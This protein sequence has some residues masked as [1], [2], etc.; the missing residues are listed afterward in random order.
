MRPMTQFVLMI[1][2][3]G[4]ILAACSSGGATSASSSEATTPSTSIQAS[5]TAPR[6][7]VASSSA[8]SSSSC[9]GNAAPAVKTAL[10]SFTA[11]T[12]VLVIGG[13][14]EVSVETSLPSSDPLTPNSSRAV[15][16]CNAA[17]KVAYVDGVDSLSVDW[18]DHHE[19]A[20]AQKGMPCIP[21]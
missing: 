13:C 3:L 14:H 4:L 19:A 8:Q 6:A 15:A 1:T 5:S 2:G 9:G 17:S 12:N 20:A 16:I 11:V 7:S 21:G 18:A 10:H